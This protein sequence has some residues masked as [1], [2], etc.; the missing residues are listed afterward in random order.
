MS[1]GAE[2]VD[3]HHLIILDPKEEALPA[4]DEEDDLPGNEAP[5]HAASTGHPWCIRRDSTTDGG[6]G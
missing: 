4:D 5:E 1:S 3:G 2:V 6:P